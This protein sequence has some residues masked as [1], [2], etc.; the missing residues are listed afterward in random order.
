M[1][2]AIP[3]LE[4]FPRFTFKR[5][6]APLPPELRPIWK[7]ASLSLILAKCCRGGKARLPKLHV[8]SWSL[9][10]PDAQA[11]FLAFLEG[12]SQPESIIVRVE[13]SLIRAIDFGVAEGL[14]EVADGKV[15]ITEKGRQVARSVDG[16]AAFEQ[17]KAFLAQV[18]HRLTEDMFR[19]LTDVEGVIR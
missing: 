11:R 15:S 16:A 19:R 3:E 2:T 12:R 9:K 4:S 6:P 17:E 7:L 13:P 8:L 10:S 1:K 14:F 5:R 18:G